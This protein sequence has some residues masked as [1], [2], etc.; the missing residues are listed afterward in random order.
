MTGLN[1]LFNGLMNNPSFAAQFY[2]KSKSC[3]WWRM[4]VQKAVADRWLAITGCRLQ[5]DMT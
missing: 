3:S 4:A 5:K 2:L 1:T